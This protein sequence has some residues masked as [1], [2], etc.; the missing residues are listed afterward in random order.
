MYDYSKLVKDYVAEPSE[1]LLLSASELGRELV[2]A[3][4]PIEELVQL[5]QEALLHLAVDCPETMSPESVHLITAPFMEMSIAYS[6]TFQERLE[7]RK[8]AEEAE[9][10]KS[11]EL[12]VLL[13]VASILSQ[14][15]SFE[16]RVGRVM[17][18]LA[19]IAQAELCILRVTESAGLR[20][21][22]YAGSPPPP[23]GLLPFTGNIPALVLEQGK[24]IVIDDYQNHPLA[25]ADYLQRGMETVLSAPV[26]SQGA[27]LGTV[28][29]GSLQPGHFT[30]DRVKFLMAIINSLGTLLE[31][32]RLEEERTRTQARVQETARLASVGELAAGVA[33]EINNPLTTVLGYAELMLGAEPTGEYQRNLQVIY[34]EALRASKIVRNLLFFARRSGPEKQY[35]D[36]NSVITRAI[37]LKSSDFRNHSIAVDVLSEPDIPKTMADG[38]QLTQ[39]FLNIL[40]N[41]EQAV[42]KAKECGEI[43]IRTAS[44]VSTISISI[45][46]DGPGIPPANMKRLFEP[47][48]TTKDVGQGTGLGLSICH[49]IIKQ[50]EG[51]LWAESHDG[52]GTTFHIELPVVAAQETAEPVPPRKAPVTSSPKRVLVVDD[53]PRVRDLL[54]KYLELQNYT[55][56]LAYD[57]PEALRRLQS[58]EYDC[59]LLDLRM[60]G[61]SGQQLYQH[62]RSLDENLARKIVFITGDTFSSGTV[63]FIS[64][65]GN[66]MIAKPFRLEDLMSSLSRIL[67]TAA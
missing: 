5:Q 54:A 60:P 29:V 10:R 9:H 4:I 62:I 36:L 31:N 42:F 25:S 17:E 66:P 38:H 45:S 2:L 47:F 63:N 50:H 33:H 22:G 15:G 43:T 51:E 13:E 21:V 18:E 55:V 26:A 48:F 56:E 32:M 3:D 58:A 12:R 53:E 65:T 49:G 23:V 7:G 35:L 64:Q 39:V 34:D 27:I 30:D 37:E 57:G 19:L 1:S 41:A 11:E 16:H 20:L 14:P 44:T 28:S 67:E 24:A 52:E 46:D 59:V 8:R 61:M 40:T 6:L